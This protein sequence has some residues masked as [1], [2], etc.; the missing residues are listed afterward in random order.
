MEEQAAVDSDLASAIDDS[1]V[2][3]IDFGT[4]KVIILS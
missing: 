1:D 4:R 2:E 3:D